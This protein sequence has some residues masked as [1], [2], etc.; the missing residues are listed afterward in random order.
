M[1]HKNWRSTDL[2]RLELLVSGRHNINDIQMTLKTLWMK[3]KKTV[4][5]AWIEPISEYS[6]IIETQYTSFNFFLFFLSVCP[7]HSLSLSHSL[8]LS[9]TLTNTWKTLIFHFYFRIRSPFG[10]TIRMFSVTPFSNQL[11]SKISH[12]NESSV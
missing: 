8:T 9:Y 4:V 7:S 3:E 12:A 6:S 2:N 10:D 11:V 5:R 1:I